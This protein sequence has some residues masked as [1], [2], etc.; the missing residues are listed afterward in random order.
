[1]IR[2][3]IKRDD[4]ITAKVSKSPNAKREQ[5]EAT[6]SEAT[7]TSY[8]RV[9][10]VF[11]VFYLVATALFA[12]SSPVVYVSP[13]AT[14]PPLL[15]VVIEQQQH[16][17]H[18]HPAVMH[19]NSRVMVVHIADQSVLHSDT[20]SNYLISVLFPAASIAFISTASVKK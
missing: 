1:V 19:C 20:C 10:A 8:L 14:P 7:A 11:I 3:W 18:H 6:A 2:L 16:H 13:P 4:V 17:H 9:N 12:K 15:L 5:V